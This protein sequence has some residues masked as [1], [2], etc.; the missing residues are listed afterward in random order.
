MKAK[1]TKITALYVRVSTHDKQTKGMQSQQDALR[2]YC[3]NHNITNFK[4]YKDMMT[5]GT[6]DRPALK[7]LQADVFRGR[8]S[9]IVVWK[10]DR[11]SRSL[12]DGINLMT[13]WLERDIRIVAICQGFDFSGTVGKLI[14]S[15]LLAVAEMERQNIRENISRG[16]QMAKKNGMVIG[17]SKPK[18]TAQ[19]VAELLKQ[20]NTISQVALALNCSRQT[21]YAALKRQENVSK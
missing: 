8:V 1:M 2:E 11:I 9:T 4:I 18:I 15:V 21:V 5:G 16:M 13:D 3:L 19:D 12:R 14:M 10:I 7:E 20:G 6:I 17:G